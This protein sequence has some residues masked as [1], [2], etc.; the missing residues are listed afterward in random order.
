MQVTISNL[1]Q[2]PTLKSAKRQTETINAEI[3]QL[4]NWKQTRLA[5]WNKKRFGSAE[6]K[7]EA[8]TRRAAP[9]FRETKQEK[10]PQGSNPH[11]RETTGDDDREEEKGKPPH[12]RQTPRHPEEKCTLSNPPSP[13]GSPNQTVTKGNL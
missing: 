7:T 3:M 1:T 12:D 10:L 8:K 9:D 13:P 4:W 11:T 5:S 2:H 6:N